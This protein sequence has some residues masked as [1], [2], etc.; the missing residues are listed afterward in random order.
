MSAG[1]NARGL[2][3]SLLAGGRD[4]AR[5]GEDYAAGKRQSDSLLTA[6]VPLQQNVHRILATADLV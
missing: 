2:L 3:D 4:I 6:M 1:F 5:K